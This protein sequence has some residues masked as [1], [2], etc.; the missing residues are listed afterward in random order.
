MSISEE[1]AASVY[2]GFGN[3]CTKLFYTASE[4]QLCSIQSLDSLELIN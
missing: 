4:K 3:I 1:I 2:R